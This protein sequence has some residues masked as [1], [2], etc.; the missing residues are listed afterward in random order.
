M[1]SVAK[2]EGYKLN[3]SALKKPNFFADRKKSVEDF[4]FGK[5][6]PEDPTS[7]NKQ[8]KLFLKDYFRKKH[9]VHPYHTAELDILPLEKLE[10]ESK[11]EF[12]IEKLDPKIKDY[13]TDFVA[14]KVDVPIG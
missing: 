8:N 11:I 9:L 12:N 14:R 7:Y 13:Y 5:P 2:R 6:P 4:K 1:S 3:V 10:E